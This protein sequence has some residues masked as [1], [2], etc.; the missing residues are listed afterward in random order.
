MSFRR[1][2]SDKVMSESAPSALWLLFCC[3]MVDLDTQAIFAVDMV[4]LGNEI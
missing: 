4:L 2:R 1:S 3:E